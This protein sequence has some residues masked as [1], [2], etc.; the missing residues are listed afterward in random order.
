M[1]ACKQSSDDDAVILM[2]AA[3]IVRKDILEK[4]FHFNGT[5][6]N[7]Q[8]KNSPKSLAALMQMILAGTNIQNQTASIEDVSFSAQ[9]LT[10]LV[11]FN[12]LKRGRTET[13][14]IRH[15]IERETSLPLYIGL[16]IHTKTRKRDLVDVLFQHGLSV[17]YD[18]VLQASTDEANRV[19]KHFKRDGVVCPTNLRNG[20]FTTGNLDNIDHNP[21]ATSARSS[22]HGTAI[23]LTQ[24]VTKNDSSSIRHREGITENEKTNEKQSKSFSELPATYTDV[25]PAAF[26]SDHPIPKKPKGH[27][28]PNVSFGMQEKDRQWLSFLNSLHEN[29]QFSN[30]IN[31]S[32]SAYMANL[33]IEDPRPPA[34]TGLLPMFRESAHTLAMVKHGMDLIKQATD[35]VNPGQVPVMT[36][37]QPLYALAKKIQ[38]TWPDI[39][40]GQKFVVMMGGLHIEVSFLKVLGD[41]LDGS[42]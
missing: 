39:Y 28:T 15:N 5:L 36:V 34:I 6:V 33:Q 18:R 22:F 32:W 1:Q 25:P 9:S 8:Y 3:Q 24:H 13:S 19:L 31:I 17:S 40:G 41:F 27:I 21:S 29:D 42:G 16:L 14:G 20:L 30:E 10:Q 11:T 23:S 4:H 35:L 38:W 37:N 26:P 12:T 7:D 2:R